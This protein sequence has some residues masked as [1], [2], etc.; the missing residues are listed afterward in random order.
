MADTLRVAVAL[1]LEDRL[2][3]G[4]AGSIRGL[5]SLSASAGAAHVA[6]GALSAGLVAVGAAA[7]AATVGFGIAT[8][9]AGELQQAVAGIAAIQPDIDTSRVFSSLNLMQTRVAQSSAQLAASLEN[10]FSSF[11]ATQEQGLRAVEQFGRGAVAARTDALTFGGAVLGVLNA[12]GQSLDSVSH[13]QDVF[14]N[15]IKAGV[16]TGPELAAGLGLVTQSAKQAGLSVEELGAFIAGVTREGG[17]AAQNINNLNNLLA[18]V[19]VKEAAEGFR[20]LGVATRDSTGNFRPLLDVFTDLDQRLSK[21]TAGSRAQ[22]IQQL[23]PDIQART[24]ANVVLNQLDFI[25]AQTV[26]NQTAYGAAA[27]AY[28]RM[29]STFQTQSQLLGQSVQAG[30]AFAGNAILPVLSAITSGVQGMVSESAPRLDEWQQRINRAFETGGTQAWLR[31]IGEVAGELG[32]EVAKWLPAIQGGLQDVGDVVGPVLD[33]LWTGTVSPWVTQRGEDLG[34]KFVDEWVPATSRWIADEATPRI[35]AEL[36]KMGDSVVSW[37]GSEGA[38]KFNTAG[39]ALIDGM[40][41][42]ANQAG[43]RIRDALTEQIQ[44]ALSNLGQPEIA[45]ASERA[46]AAQFQQPATSTNGPSA[47]GS[48]AEQRRQAAED[49][50]RIWRATQ[51]EEAR[52]AAEMSQPPPAATAPPAQP[53]AARPSGTEQ[54]DLDALRR[55]E[56]EAERLQKK[57]EADA[58]SAR[59]R[60]EAEAQRAAEAARRETERLIQLH[61][62]AVAAFDRIGAEGS[63]AFAQT[64]GEG[65]KA[66]AAL[67]NAVQREAGESQ[68]AALAQSINEL[69]NR[70]RA[71]GVPAIED[72]YADM[73]EAGR[74]AVLS[75]GEEA[76]QAAL[77]KIQ[78]TA[79]AIRR[80]QTLSP[81]TFARA[82]GVANLREVMGSGFASVWDAAR[83]ATEEGGQQNIATLAQQRTAIARTLFENRDLSPDQARAFMGQVW[84]AIDEVVANRGPESIN[85]L[86]TVLGQVNFD[87]A[88]AGART[89]LEREMRAA[90]LQLDTTISRS[91]AQSRAAVVQIEQQ[92]LTELHRARVFQNIDDGRD[93]EL[94][95]VR[96]VHDARIRALQ[97]EREVTDLVRDRTREDL[98]TREGRERQIAE[99][100]RRAARPT[101]E[102][103]GGTADA[104]AARERARAA[105]FRVG[106]PA[107]DPA[108]QIA[109]LKRQWALEDQI[110]DQR[111]ARQDADRAES[112]RRAGEDRTQAQADTQLL[113]G[114]TARWEQV[115][116]AFTQIFANQDRQSAIAQTIAGHLASV[117]VA[118]AAYA[119]DTGKAQGAFVESRDRLIEI[120]NLGKTALTAYRTDA[121][122]ARDALREAQAILGGAAGATPQ[123]PELPGG[124][125]LAPAGAPML[126]PS[127]ITINVDQPILLD[128]EEMGRN[129]FHYELSQ[130]Q[131]TGQNQNRLTGRPQSPGG[132][133]G[134]GY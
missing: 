40:V 5:G 2:S 128:G 120:N 104:V 96:D 98:D 70:G 47:I 66:A 76:K 57:A 69:A 124:G 73:W 108:D 86:Q 10:L 35:V 126:G 127:S 78:E 22:V 119:A 4:L 115:R 32:T 103:V 7:G 116:T 25:R 74:Q 52:L 131:L 91:Q 100:R 29:S 28:E 50:W 12:Y 93:R 134:Y 49:A 125:P 77:A 101:G 36:D 46:F 41:S 20:L 56:Q 94:Q 75:K 44:N 80:E 13:V 81:E 129:V 60:A 6:V 65:A 27:E 26:E 11:D 68:G 18:K 15:T 92:A 16:V 19:N 107:N 110:R 105:G 118:T 83:R 111:R 89:R 59:R 97:E 87:V 113:D 33:E 31:E 82:V 123:T 85:R 42:A 9:R 99:L 109:E 53:R 30:F 24:A 79:E 64:F 37:A 90:Q 23:F 102:G 51:D 84:D 130:A 45:S 132:F 17:P 54:L 95:A 72:M 21:L 88:I 34:T 63:Q 8:Q 114:V 67:T 39:G 62:D 58:E 48:E 106:A 117:T 55:A 71:I 1:G 14:F 38:A 43:R 3:Q 112:Q 61:A 122:A 133:G 121:E